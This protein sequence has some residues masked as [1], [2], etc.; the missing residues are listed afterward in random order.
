MEKF[1]VIIIGGGAS[2]LMSATL[3]RAKTLLLERGER[4]GRKLSATGNGQGNLSNANLSVD[5]YFSNHRKYKIAK[6]LKDNPPQKTLDYFKSLGVMFTTDERGRIYP[7]S[8]Q[9]SAI[10]D[11]LRYEVA[12]LGVVVKTSTTVQKIEKVKDGYKISSDN[13]EFFAPFVIVATGGKSA[14]N[15]GTDGN[16]YE[17]VKPLGITV[18]DT[19]PSLVQLKTDTTYTKMLKGIRVQ[20]KAKFCKK[21]GEGD[22][23]FTDY[24]ISGDLVFRLSAFGRE[25]EIEIDLLPSIEKSELIEILQKKKERGVYPKGELLSGI[26]NNQVGR[27]VIKRV[28]SEEPTLLADCVKKFTLFVSGSLGFD[29][30]QVTKG[31]VHLHDVTENMESKKHRGLY[32]TGEILDVDGECGGYNLQWAFSSAMTVA[33]RINGKIKRN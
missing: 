33:T 9:A 17:L 13:G 26:L 1:E 8:R 22:I 24:G 6:I 30:A 7:S 23:I 21:E 5:N 25:G 32:F 12:R 20:A 28:G 4:V 10:T 14:K 18:T 19:Y 27:A 31:G 16:G 11:A 29:Y 2:G 3:L 15:F